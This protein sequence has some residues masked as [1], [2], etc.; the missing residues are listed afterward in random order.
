MFSDSRRKEDGALWKGKV[1]SKLMALWWSGVSILAF[2]STV[3][4]MHHSL[5]ES[6]SMKCI[7]DRQGT[8]P[9]RRMARTLSHCSTGSS[10]GARVECYT[11]FDM[12]VI[13][14]FVAMV[15][16]QPGV[17]FLHFCI[18]LSGWPCVEKCA[19]RLP[20]MSQCLIVGCSG[21]QFGWIKIATNEH[22]KSS[23]FG[24]ICPSRMVFASTDTC[25]M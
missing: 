10:A 9:H 4:N 22:K 3:S 6:N 25:I 17:F 15:S 16:F 12:F 21:K 5:L 24:S 1:Q 19:A 14:M 23:H 20:T 13:A 7:R 18:R 11:T 2:H 8:T